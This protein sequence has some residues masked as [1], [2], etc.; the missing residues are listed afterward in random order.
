MAKVD[1]FSSARTG[2]GTEILT[3]DGTCDLPTALHVEQ[4]IVTALDAGTTDIIIDLRG[5]TSLRAPMLHMLFRGLIRI[6]GQHGRLVLIRPNA[7]V[8]GEFERS[9]LDRGFLSYP[10]LEGALEVVNR[11]R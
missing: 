3:L 8:W 11:D 10:D 5:V 2:D 7:Y 6:K 1:S 9:G 4:R